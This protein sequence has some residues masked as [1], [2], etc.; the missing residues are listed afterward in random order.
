MLFACLYR[1]PEPK[2][3]DQGWVCDQE[4]D[5]DGCQDEEQN[6]EEGP[7]RCPFYTFHCLVDDVCISLA[8][9]CNGIIECSDGADETGACQGQC[10]LWITPHH[11]QMT[12]LTIIYLCLSFGL[13]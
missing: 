12:K 6:C 4:C 10:Q 7:S 3:I 9:V 11:L 5:C 2:C 13:T 8:R 1:D